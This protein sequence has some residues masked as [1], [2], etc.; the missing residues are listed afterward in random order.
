LGGSLDKPTTGLSRRLRQRLSAVA[1]RAAQEIVAR[2]RGVLAVYLA[3]SAARDEATESSDLDMTAIIQEDAASRQPPIIIAGIPVFY[4]LCPL[5]HYLDIE[6][7]LTG[8][9]VLSAQVVDAVAL[10]DPDGMFSRI[11]RAVLRRYDD[12]FY[13]KARVALSLDEAERQSLL[14]RLAARHGRAREAPS[15]LAESVVYGL[16]PAFSF[17]AGQPPTER[18]CL[19][20]LKPTCE[21]VGAESIYDEILSFL[22]L[23]EASNRWAEEAISAVGALT[24]L[25]GAALRKHNPQLYQ[26]NADWLSN[27]MAEYFAAGSRELLRDGLRE[28]SI[29]CCM[30]IASRVLGIMREAGG[31]LPFHVLDDVE[32]LGSAVFGTKAI[33]QEALHARLEHAAAAVEQTRRLAGLQLQRATPVRRERKARD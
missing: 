28:A 3:G 25:A 9:V 15:H 12:P 11:Q 10:Y 1:Q 2:H 32:Q 22:G 31:S 21:A 29:Y 16:A 13:L 30:V 17:L 4:R 19:A 33:G 24:N 27:A 5:H 18:K 7:L 8:S 20:A 14:A 26:S 6:G 23:E